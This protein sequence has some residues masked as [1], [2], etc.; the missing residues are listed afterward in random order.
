MHFKLLRNWIQRPQSPPLMASVHLTPFQE[1]P[2]CWGWRRWQG[3]DKHSH[4]CACSIQ[5]PPLVSGRTTRGPST[6]FIKEKGRGTR[7]RLDAPLVLGSMHLRKRCR[8]RCVPQRGSWRILMTSTS[9]PDQR[10]WAMLWQPAFR[11]CGLTPGSE[12]PTTEHGIKVLGTSLGHENFVNLTFGTDS[13][14]AQKI[15]TRIPTLPDVQ[16]GMASPARLRLHESE[17]LVESGQ[18]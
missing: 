11:S 12:V 18:T 4:L 14:E 15:L 16:S 10:E 9:R 5:N 1:E 3:G 17:T 2:C 8:G 7:G 6:R 13:A